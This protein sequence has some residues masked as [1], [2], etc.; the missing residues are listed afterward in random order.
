MKPEN[1][2]QI[3]VTQIL[4]STYNARALTVQLNNSKHIQK[5]IIKPF[6]NLQ[7]SISIAV[8]VVDSSTE[9]AGEFQSH[10]ERNPQT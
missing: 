4:S 6:L 5:V 8:N 10:R 7:G 9:T 2:F 3:Q 1:R